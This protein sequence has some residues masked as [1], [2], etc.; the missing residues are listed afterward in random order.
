MGVLIPIKTETPEVVPVMTVIY[1]GGRHL[2]IQ[3]SLGSLPAELVVEAGV[4]T[5]MVYLL[6][7]AMAVPAMSGLA[8]EEEIV[9][10]GMVAMEIPIAQP[11]INLALGEVVAVEV[12]VEVEVEMEVQVVQ[13]GAVE[14]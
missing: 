11:S 4:L 14:F 7:E 1:T 6:V 10:A 5:R 3:V 13:V 8:E 9:R 12:E 2:I